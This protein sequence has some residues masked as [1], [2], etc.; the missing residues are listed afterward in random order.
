MVKHIKENPGIQKPR[1]LIEAGCFNGT[2]MWNRV[3]RIYRN[4]YVQ[5]KNVWFD[6]FVDFH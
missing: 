3:I 2:T 6:L 1:Y 4:V 5:I